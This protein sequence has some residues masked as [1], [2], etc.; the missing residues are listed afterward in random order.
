[1]KIGNDMGFQLR[2]TLGKNSPEEQIVAENST[3]SSAG[4]E[5]TVESAGT[6]RTSN[7]LASNFVQSD[8]EPSRYIQGVLAG[9]QVRSEFG[10]KMQGLVESYNLQ[11]ASEDEGS[12]A[13]RYLIGK[14][15]ARAAEAVRNEEVAETEAKRLAKEREAAEEESE[16]KLEEKAAGNDDETAASGNAAGQQSGETATVQDTAAQTESADGSQGA[17]GVAV[18]VS[19]AAQQTAGATAVQSGTSLDIVV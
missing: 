15:A 10:A 17:T 12:Y 7:L 3:L 1:M 11:I 16:K 19:D 6:A 8:S 14:K 2:T 4:T 18:S 5:K 9:F 13:A